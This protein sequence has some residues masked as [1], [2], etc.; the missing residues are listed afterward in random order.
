MDLGTCVITIAANNFLVLDLAR[1]VIGIDVE[2]LIKT[3]YS[4]TAPQPLF[5]MAVA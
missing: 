2:R 4:V 5:I 1:D 3:K